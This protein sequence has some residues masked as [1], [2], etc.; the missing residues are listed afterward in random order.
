[1]GSE[2]L[3]QEAAKDSEDADSGVDEVKDDSVPA[4]KDD[5]ASSRWQFSGEL[6]ID[7]MICHA[8]SGAYDLDQRRLQIEEEN[9]AWAPT[10]A[11]RF[12]TSRWTCF[13]DQGGLGP[14]RRSDPEE[15]ADGELR[16]VS[17]RS[18][19]ILSSWT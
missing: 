11:L 4:A 2:A 9:F 15:D 18:R 19:T 5:E 1:M 10:A 6:E 17:I 7:C 12:G 16:R 3:N 13:D 14:E 8:V